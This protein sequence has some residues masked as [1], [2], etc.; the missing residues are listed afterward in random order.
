M[1]WGSSN[2][3][4]VLIICSLIALEETPSF[5]EQAGVTLVGHIRYHGSI[6]PPQ[7]LQVNR[8]PE[9]CGETVTVQP[10]MVSRSSAGVR[11]GEVGMVEGD[12]VPLHKLVLIALHVQEAGVLDEF[13]NLPSAYNLGHVHERPFSIPD[14]RIV[15][16]R[17][18][19]S[20]D[21]GLSIAG[22]DGGLVGNEQVSSSVRTRGSRRQRT[23]GGRLPVYS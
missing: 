1:H 12:Q 14:V 9:I 4:T 10:L 23:F 16:H 13:F 15:K 17:V 2:L 3:A 11:D 6:S 8:D 19:V 20:E 5:A 7:Q 18:I 21:K 22:E